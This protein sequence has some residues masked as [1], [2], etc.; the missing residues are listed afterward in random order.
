MPRLMGSLEEGEIQ[1]FDTAPTLQ[2]RRQ[3]GGQLIIEN[4][5]EEPAPS[6]I[7]PAP[8]RETLQM[9]DD[10][11]KNIQENLRLAEQ[12]QDP[13]VAFQHIANI[14]ASIAKK[15]ADFTKE[16]QGM[17][18]AEYQIPQ[19][20][21]ALK[22]SEQKDRAHPLW[23]QYQRDTPATA[24]VRQKLQSAKNAAMASVEERL[25]SNPVYASLITQASTLAKAGESI[26]T[27]KLN[28]EQ[29]I[30]MQTEQFMAGIG[31]EGKRVL[32]TLFPDRAENNNALR[33]SY[34]LAPNKKEIQE[35]IQTPKEFVPTAAFRGNITALNYL[36]QHER[37][38]GNENAVKAIR[39]GYKA[40][41]SPEATKEALNY[42]AA[43]GLFSG[44]TG[45]ALKEQY[46]LALNPGMQTNAEARKD[47][48]IK[49][50]D[51]AERYTRLKITE[52]FNEDIMNRGVEPAWLK[53]ASKNPAVTPTGKI[54]V[55]Q[56]IA[57][58]N[59]APTVQERQARI[60]E[61]TSYYEQSVQTYNKSGTAFEMDPF[62]I[63]AMKAR[64]ATSRIG[65]DYILGPNT[66]EQEFYEKWE[67]N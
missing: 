31:T 54:S 48:R 43:R 50:G 1:T 40:T 8:S 2:V 55:D 67:P 3:E 59:Q 35:L 18:F 49:Q 37:Q 24:E 45:K 34:E 60:R 52:A 61:L 21:E 5:K 6:I 33:A 23:E 30:E 15:K 22:F 19:L 17:A 57:L 12:E 27:K 66:T 16:A 63:N 64:A 56:A 46:E 4:R 10:L 51:I 38:V 62:A 13:Q 26:L 36:E 41:L 7:R 44:K 25:A 20:E 29:L 32:S 14:N 47:A 39:E 53:E 65:L 42:M 11:F 9:E 58:A 28:K